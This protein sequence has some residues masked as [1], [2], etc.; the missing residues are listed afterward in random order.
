MTAKTISKTIS[1]DLVEGLAVLFNCL[2][3]SFILSLLAALGLALL[4]FRSPGDIRSNTDGDDEED[5]NGYN[6]KAHSASLAG[7]ALSPYEDMPWSAR[8]WPRT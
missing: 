3:E 6:A 8:P 7:S 4:R 5:G 2:V 1:T